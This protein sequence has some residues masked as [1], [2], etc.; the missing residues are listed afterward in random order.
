MDKNTNFSL[1]GSAESAP[2]SQIFPNIDK[3]CIKSLLKEFLE[4]YIESLEYGDGKWI[5][6]YVD[7]FLEKSNVWNAYE[8]R[9]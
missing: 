8:N 5:S 9:K 4:D 6:G 7:R 1:V 3:E 2:I